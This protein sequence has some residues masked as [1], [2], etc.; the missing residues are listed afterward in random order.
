[1]RRRDFFLIDCSADSVVT[2]R[3][4]AAARDTKYRLLERKVARGVWA[5]RC[6]PPNT[7]ALLAETNVRIPGNDISLQGYA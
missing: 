3:V 5:F 2:Y 4:G 6:S 7:G 1:M